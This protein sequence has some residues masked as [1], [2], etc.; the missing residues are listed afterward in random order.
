VPTWATWPWMQKLSAWGSVAGTSGRFRNN[1]L[2]LESWTGLEVHVAGADGIL[3]KSSSFEV[4]CNV[5]WE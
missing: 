5:Y 4:C 2:E 3:E 1:R